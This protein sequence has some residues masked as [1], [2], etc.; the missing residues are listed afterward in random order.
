MHS[1]PG[2][3]RRCAGRTIRS[4]RSRPHH[5]PPVEAPVEAIDM[6]IE[7]DAMEPVGEIQK[8]LRDAIA[9]AVAGRRLVVGTAILTAILALLTLRMIEPSFTAT[10]IVGP[11]AAEGLLSEGVPLSGSTING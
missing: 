5:S 2:L 8:M 1:W 10:L 3:M 9:I 6:P 11:T 7:I 4:S